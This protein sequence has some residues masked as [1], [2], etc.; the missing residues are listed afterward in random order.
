MPEKREKMASIRGS[1]LRFLLAEGRRRRGEDADVLG[2]SRGAFGRRRCGG[3]VQVR[4]RPWKRRLGLGSEGKKR[5]RRSRWS[6]GSSFILGGGGARA[7][8]QH[9]KATE[10][11]PWR[12]RDFTVAPGRRREEERMTGGSP[13]S[14]I[15]PFSLFRNSSKRFVFN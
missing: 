14:G 12:S 9:G 7:S 11:W 3:G 5:G 13:L 2:W 4:S 6:W 15:S 10:P 1:R 8:E